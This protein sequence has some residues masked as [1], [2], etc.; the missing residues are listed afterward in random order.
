MRHVLF[1]AVATLVVGSIVSASCTADDSTETYNGTAGGSAIGGS[2][3]D[4]GSGG[5][6]SQA[7]SDETSGSS[8]NGG[9]NTATGGSAGSGTGGMGTG[10]TPAAIDAGGLAG[11][12]GA[13]GAGGG[14]MMDTI[15]SIAGK[16]NGFGDT[17]KD[18]FMLLGCYAQA[19]QDCITVPSGTQCP[20]Q[21]GSLPFE[22]QGIIARE[23]FTI[24]GTPG[25]SYLL[26]IS[27]NGIAEAKYYQDG[28]RA[29]GNADPKDPDVVTGTDTFYTGGTPVKFEF[30]NIYK[31]IAKDT[32]GKEMQ[33]YY[34][35]SFP[36]TNTPYENHQTFPI[37]FTHDIVV[38]GGGSVQLFT[39][40]A[41]CHAIDNCGPGFRTTSCPVAAGRN[42]PNEPNLTVP[43]TYLGKPVSGMNLRNGSA[44]PFHSQIFHIKVVKVTAMP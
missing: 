17:L 39:S 29:A 41:N 27:V 21:N 23:D 42:V 33:H 3:G 18:T 24:G 6:S 13:G 16:P 12:A 11:S 32:A 10:G 44:Q 31:L 40:D 7:G 34:F 20:N 5:S 14:T 9:S 15:D 19:G 28:V 22:E 35:N 1:S 26:T 25:K 38:M 2:G 4:P 43:S 37:S 8:S 36:K 30:Y